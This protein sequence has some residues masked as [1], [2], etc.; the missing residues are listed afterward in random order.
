[1]ALGGYGP[2]QYLHLL[3]AKARSLKPRLV[4]CAIYVGN[5]LFDIYNRTKGGERIANIFVSEKETIKPLRGLR[6]TLAHHSVLYRTITQS[7]LF[8]FVRH[9]EATANPDRRRIGGHYLSAN[10]VM[11]FVDIDTPEIAQAYARMEDILTEMVSYSNKNGMAFVLT[12]IPT[13]ETVYFPHIKAGLTHTELDDFQKLAHAEAKI[14]SGISALAS[15]LKIRSIDM[16]P[17]LRKAVAEGRPVYS[18]NDGHPNALGYGLIAKAVFE[19]V[20]KH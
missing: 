1:M 11:K 17:V 19:Q 9:N 2:L 16:L 10:R 6:D 14:R 20:G 18:F 8:D 3:K 13:K 15:R 12:V 5:D 4:I 7:P